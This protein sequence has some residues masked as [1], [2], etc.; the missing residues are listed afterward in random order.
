MKYAINIAKNKLS[1]ACFD[2]SKAPLK[3]KKNTKQYKQ[4][5]QHAHLHDTLTIFYI[6]MQ[7][8]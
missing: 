3:R 5:I 1:L 6:I 8:N 4:N 2:L 7:T